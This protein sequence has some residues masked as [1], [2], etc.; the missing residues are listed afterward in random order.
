M[1]GDDKLNQYLTTASSINVQSKVFAEW[2]LNWSSNISKI[3]NYRY[4]PTSPSDPN[5]I[6][7]TS[8][9][10]DDYA[11]SYTGATDA[12]IVIDGGYDKNDQP[13]GFISKKTRNSLLYSL[14]DCF[15][16]FRPRSGINKASL[17]SGHFLHHSNKDM[18]ARPRYY[19]ADKADKFKYWSSF[20]TEAGYDRGLSFRSG[21]SFFIEDAA[22]FVVYNEKISTNRVVVKMQTHVGTKNLGPFY[23]ASSQLNDPYYGYVNS[24]T[25]ESWSIQYLED[26]QWKTAISFTA[27]SSRADGSPIIGPDGYV[28]IFYGLNVPPA[29]RTI[30][31]F[32]SEII[33]DTMLPLNPKVGDAYLVK[34]DENDLGLFHI[35]TATGFKTFTPTYGWQLLDGDIV[36]YRN[37]LTKVSSAYSYK[38]LISNSIKYRQFSNISGLRVVVTTMHRN[39]STFDLIELSPRL[40]ADMTDY[41]ENLNLDKTASDLGVSGMPV[42]QL[43]TSTG[44]ISMFDYDNTFNPN[45]DKSIIGK[46]L[47]Q[48]AKFLVY[49]Q[50]I[51]DD[52]SKYL[53][54]IKHLYSKGMPVFNAS[55]RSADFDLRDY[56]SVFESQECPDLL[57]QDVSLSVAIATLL[58][59]VGF[60]NYKFYRT[61]NDNDLIIPYFFVNKDKSVAQALQDLAIASQSSMFFDEENNFIVMA[62]NY[63]M[64]TI[65]ER[66][67]DMI[68]S[69]EQTGSLSANI[70]AIS[71]NETK[72]LNDGSISYKNY[73]IQKTTGKLKQQAQLDIDRTWIYKPVLLWQAS[74][75]NFTK[76]QNDEF[77]QGTFS[78][79]AVPL[80]T[81]LGK[82]VPIV[83][84]GVVINN[85]MDLGM[86]VLSGLSRYNGYF[87]ANGEIIKYDAVQFVTSQGT[88]WI[89][90]PQEYADYFSK[91]SFGGSMYP[92][93]LVR[94]FAQPYYQTVN[95]ITKFKE[96]PVE[97][98]GRMQFGTGYRK[99]DGTVEPCV[100]NAGLS[101]EWQNATV[102]G[103]R[104]S[105]SDMLSSKTEDALSK[106]KGISLA[107]T[108]IAG[109][110]VAATA[111][112]GIV[113][114]FM[115][116]TYLTDK[117]T[118][119]LKTAQKGSVQASALVLEGP[120]FAAEDK[121]S[122]YLAYIPKQ[123]DSK[124][125]HFGARLRLIGKKSSKPDL[126]NKQTPNGSMS[127]FSDASIGA[128]SGGITVLNNPA[129]NAGYYFEL[130]AL[131]KENMDVAGENTPI[132]NLVFYKVKGGT[133]SLA[134]PVKLWEGSYPIIVDNGN[135]TG[136]E[137]TFADGSPAST[138]DI[139]VEYKDTGNVRRFYLSLNGS[140]I[141]TVDDL[142][143]LP[144]YNNFGPFIRGTSRLMFE[145]IYALSQNHSL[146][147]NANLETPM[148]A[149]FTNDSS[150]QT[151]EVLRKYSMSGAIQSTYLTG[152]STSQDPKFN[153]Y[154]EEFGTIMREAAYFNIRFDKAFPALM[155]MPV[156]TI[157]GMR[158][159]TMSGYR[160]SAYGAEFMI[161]NATDTFLDISENSTNYLKIQGVSFTQSSER[162]LTVDEILS[163][164]SDLSDVD[165]LQKNILHSPQAA[166]TLKN[167][168]KDSV[169]MYGKN[170]FQ[171]SSPYI[172]STDAAQ[173]L[174]SW[175]I[176]KINKPRRNIGLSLFGGSVLQLGDIV[177]VFWTDNS[178]IDQLINRDQRFV[179]YH[180]TYDSGPDG[181]STTVY[182]SEVI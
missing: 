66:P 22:P 72:A 74:Q 168:L 32:K 167:Q 23:T 156:P 108:G 63:M 21:N 13:L 4:R 117:D 94:I 127:Y 136:Q 102:N 9:D 27:S 54:P 14:E 161:F 91:I 51:I 7:Q 82:E 53:I 25:P 163:K 85:T 69:G 73:Y 12:D 48:S 178:G 2:N 98:H 181:P 179:V 29:Y 76:P 99:A 1:F 159:Y 126:E 166:Q 158:G 55:S 177:Q 105:F 18:Y 47:K 26:S 5:Y 145:N 104:M 95:G 135:F 77:G 100:H 96:G 176:T 35:Y 121:P 146:N 17:F 122:E 60:S 61:E 129:T 75:A 103:C 88:V 41:T 87:Y 3:G 56:F 131:T 65:S 124:F 39:D 80:N 143:P 125:V 160:P 64:P 119:A 67:T 30:F 45:Y 79:A 182:M 62:K 152:I 157:T 20:R 43:L 171:I 28:E 139:Y 8:Y 70:E 113:R 118:N 173:E 144:V 83:K 133:D 138:Y 169:T 111:K 164:N 93:G 11:N 142:D 137:R 140:V 150:L 31:N 49:E 34:V 16:R 134:N 172:Q 107:S 109:T 10:Q 149:I 147:S 92:T 46:Y 130:M 15:N 58:D 52:G 148:N 174:L 110:K 86:P 44:K 68:V 101:S 81:T 170:A 57:M 36:D 90:S 78:L 40:F 151:N 132:A 153:I 115:S 38:D 42:G 120:S 97:K 89:Q 180:I 141:A 162:T 112:S 128:S 114:N 50:I 116:S 106:S 19:M 123:L 6:I 37:T 33:S 71:T 175:L 24:R 154:F 59:S 84:D 165:N 155:S